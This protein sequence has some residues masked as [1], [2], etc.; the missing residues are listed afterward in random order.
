MAFHAS[1]QFHATIHAHNALGHST[2]QGKGPSLF[3]EVFLRPV[4]EYWLIRENGVRS[5]AG[6]HDELWQFQSDGIVNIDLPHLH[7]LGADGG[8][9]YIVFEKRGRC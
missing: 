8:R 6:V 7:R 4:A 5:Q 9:Q 1:D 2:L 3:P